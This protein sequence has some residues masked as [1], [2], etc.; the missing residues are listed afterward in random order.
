MF[1]HPPL[2]LKTAPRGDIRVA[3]CTLCAVLV[4]VESNGLAQH[5]RFHRAVVLAAGQD[6]TPQDQR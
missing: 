5:E 6:S 3:V 4:S 2:V 1:N